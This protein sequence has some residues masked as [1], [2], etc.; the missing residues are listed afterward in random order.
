MTTGRKIGRK[1]AMQAWTPEVLKQ[2]HRWFN[3][4]KELRQPR[5][6][7]ELAAQLDMDRKTLYNL[8]RR[9]TLGTKQTSSSRLENEKRLRDSIDRLL[10]KP[11]P[12]QLQITPQ[13]QQPA[14]A[15]PAHTPPERE[16]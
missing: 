2:V 6:A 8:H 12:T 16:H 5:T 11:Q 4:P 10:P 3:T 13:L 7:K 15:P 1:L 9:S 14:M